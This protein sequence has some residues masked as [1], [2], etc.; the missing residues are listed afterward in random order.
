MPGVIVVLVLGLMWA[1]LEGNQFLLVEMGLLS[2]IAVSQ[3]APA[4]FLGLYWRGG[5][6]KG[7]LTA[8]S[9][10]TNPHILSLSPPINLDPKWLGAHPA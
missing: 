7:A 6:R 1:Q 10:G 8:I 4:V 2:F 3:V 5:N 9:I